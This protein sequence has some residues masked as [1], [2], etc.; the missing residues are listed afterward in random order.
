MPS[1][2]ALLRR[3]LTF[4][5]SISKFS[6]VNGSASPPETPTRTLSSKTAEMKPIRKEPVP[7]EDCFISNSTLADTS[8]VSTSKRWTA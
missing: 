6:V 8:P 2:V 5:F 1:G 4:F 7:L 3:Q